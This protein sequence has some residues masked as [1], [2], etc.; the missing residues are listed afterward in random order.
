MCI[1][2]RS[3]IERSGVNGLAQ[4]RLTRQ[5]VEHEVISHFKTGIYTYIYPLSAVTSL[6]VFRTATTSS[7][8]PSRRYS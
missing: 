5:M 2:A 3:G 4:L 1:Y 8:V 6:A 7:R